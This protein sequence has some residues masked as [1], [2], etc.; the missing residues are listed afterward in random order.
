MKIVINRFFA[1]SSKTFIILE[2]LA[3]F[4]AFI[5]SFKKDAKK[6]ESESEYEVGVPP[7]NEAVRADLQERRNKV[8]ELLEPV[9][10]NW[11]FIEN[12]LLWKN[13]LPACTCFFFISVVFW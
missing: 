12:T 8:A 3:R 2:M 9:D 4:K 6:E 7:E 1:K 5:A 10:K 13:A 11:E